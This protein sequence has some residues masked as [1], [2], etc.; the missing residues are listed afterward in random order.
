[1]K[2]DKIT[3]KQAAKILGR[4]KKTISQYVKNGWL[5]PERLDSKRG[6][7]EYRFSK[8]ELLKFQKPEKTEEKR[9]TRPEEELIALLT[10]QLK[11]KDEQI[12]EL[13]ERSRE[14]NILLKGLQNQL[15]LTGD[16]KEDRKDRGERQVKKK[17][18]WFKGL[19][20]KKEGD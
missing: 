11:V 20:G 12:R 19:F 17:K 14:N 7:L 6:A 2:E 1:M 9:K 5:N 16:K 15:L 10:D 3:L 4:S 8:S 18:G 13:L